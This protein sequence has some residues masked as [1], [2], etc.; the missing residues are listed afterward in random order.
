MEA[1]DENIDAININSLHH[2]LGIFTMTEDNQK[3]II[4]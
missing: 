3:N 1:L 4:T 2:I